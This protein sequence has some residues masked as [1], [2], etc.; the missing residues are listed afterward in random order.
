ML[1]SRLIASRA[2]PDAPDDP[3]TMTDPP[4]ER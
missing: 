1:V 4:T 2:L 3:G